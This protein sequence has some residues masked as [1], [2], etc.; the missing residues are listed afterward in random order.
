MKK[1]FSLPLIFII[2]NHAVAQNVG[3]GTSTPIGALNIFKT[4]SSI[5]NFHNASTGS[6]ISDGFFVGNMGGNT[7]YIWNNENAAIRFGTNNNERLVILGDGNVGI[8]YSGPT[9]K[10]SVNGTIYSNG[11]YNNGNSETFG[12]F[13]AYST[14]NFSNIVNVNGTLNANGN[15]A[16]DGNIT[17]NSG[18]GIVRSNDANQ[19]VIDEFSTPANLNFTINAGSS[20]C[21]IG[22]TFS[23]F[24]SPPSIAFGRLTNSTNPGFISFTIE[25]I[26][27]NSAQIRITNI[28]NAPSTGTNATLHAMIIGRK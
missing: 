6:T 26:T 21:C 10:L 25:S 5:L 22:F 8:G 12:T 23:A 11:L 27:N 1:L 19:L 7:S 18:F 2:L 13:Y 14:A 16:V 9:Y 20:L 4:D 28:G 24:T 3:I 17:T 15:L